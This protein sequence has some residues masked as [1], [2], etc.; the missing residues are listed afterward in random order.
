[1][2]KLSFFF[3]FAPTAH[4]REVFPAI[5]FLPTSYVFYILV[6][7]S[8][9]FI[10]STPSWKWRPTLF[11][12]ELR[13]LFL[14]PSGHSVKKNCQIVEEV[15]TMTEQVVKS[16]DL[17]RQTK[18]CM[19][20][21]FTNCVRNIIEKAVIIYV[22]IPQ[23]RKIKKFQLH[24][25]DQSFEHNGIGIS[26]QKKLESLEEKKAVHTSCKHGVR[27]IC[28][29]Y[30]KGGPAGKL[31]WCEPPRDH[32]DYRRRDN[33]QRSSPQNTG[34]A[35]TVTT[36]SLEECDFGHALGARTFYTSPLRKCQKAYRKTFWILII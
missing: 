13:H 25:I 29:L 7:S 31:T 1:M 15:W 19:A 20:V 6:F 21:F 3:I 16:K 32:L 12:L 22:V 17:R 5:L 36:L 18:E 27:R 24:I 2:K 8:F 28:Q 4:V 11:L 33:I 9:S 30:T 23:N 34:R 14:W 35:K 10:F 26:Y